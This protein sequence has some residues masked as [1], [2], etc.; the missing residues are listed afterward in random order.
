MR[1]TFFVAI[2]SLFVA[3]T[4]T[5]QD[6]SLLG[7]LKGHSDYSTFVSLLESSGLSSDLDGSTK[8]TVFAPSNAAFAKVPAANLEAIKKD[9]AALKK[10]LQYHIIL[11][12]IPANQLLRLKTART[13]EGTRV[14]F[15]MKGG[16]SSVQDA[17]IT[18]PDIKASNGVIHGVNS[19][20]KLK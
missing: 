3:T 8:Y 14:E 6:K 1:K 12:S 13:I 18:Q 15:M 11:N 20:L 19:V 17:E 2:L 7:T 9:P 10:M 5:A 4:G 16:K